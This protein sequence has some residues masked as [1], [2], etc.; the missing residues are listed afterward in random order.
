MCGNPFKSSSST[1]KV[2]VADPTPTAV[3]TQEVDTTGSDADKQRRKRGYMATRVAQD[4]N[5]LT[6]QTGK[7]TT[8]G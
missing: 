3:T 6:D 5:V 7:R 1:P 8:L 4:R 2:Q